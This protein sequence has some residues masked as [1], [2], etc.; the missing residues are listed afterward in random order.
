MSAADYARV[1]RE[2]DEL[3]SLLE[4]AREQLARR[5]D[6]SPVPDELAALRCVAEHARADVSLCAFF[7]WVFGLIGRTLYQQARLLE[8]QQEVTDLRAQTDTLRGFLSQACM[9]FNGQRDMR[10]REALQIRVV[11]AEASLL[12]RDVL[13]GQLRGKLAA[14]E[15][16][17]AQLHQASDGGAFRWMHSMC[18][19]LSA[20][21][22]VAQE[23]VER[24]RHAGGQPAGKRS[25]A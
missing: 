20:R 24:L 11:S 19:E 16:V 14:N 5:R 2:R 23:E 25:R 15:R 17:I 4:D 7:G 18:M 6:C 22:G 10:D 3:A 13:L 12:Q 8:L 1:M 21:L 9:P